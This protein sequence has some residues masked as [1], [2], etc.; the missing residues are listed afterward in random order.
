MSWPD[1]YRQQAH[2]CV[3][4]YEATGDAFYFKAA[5]T[6]LDLAAEWNERK[7]EDSNPSA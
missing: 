5:Q 3:I 6:Y 7:A 1:R 4:Q 2:I